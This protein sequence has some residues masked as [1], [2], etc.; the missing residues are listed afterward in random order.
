MKRLYRSRGQKIIGG[1]CGGL[2]EY[3]DVDPV[4]IRIIWFIAFFLQGL[5]LLAYIIAWIIIPVEPKTL[6]HEEKSEMKVEEK[7]ESISHNTRILGGIIL[8]LL[9][10]FFFMFSIRGVWY[11]HKPI[12]HIVRSSYRYFEDIVSFSW[13]YFVPVLLISL[14]I[15][16]I[17]QKE[18]R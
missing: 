6:N 16:V 12:G 9:G 2:G 14:G 17:V 8:I 15:Y 4:I 11:F 18:K 7:K 3:F 1:V 5:G 13:R 10:V